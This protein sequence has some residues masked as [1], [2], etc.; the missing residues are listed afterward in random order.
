[1]SALG[2]LVNDRV[3]R[4]IRYEEGRLSCEEIIELFQELINDG[5]AWSLQG[6]YGRAALHLIE[7]GYCSV[8]EN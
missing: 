2:I 3:D 6:S 7:Q 5:S 1:M 8:P 4:I